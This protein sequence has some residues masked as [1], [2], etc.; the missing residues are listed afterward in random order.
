MPGLGALPLDVLDLVLLHVGSDWWGVVRL[1]CRKWHALIKR[2]CKAPRLRLRCFA[3]RRPLCEWAL[4]NDCLVPE[5]S[6]IA[7]VWTKENCGGSYKR[8]A[9]MMYAADAGA[10]D[11]LE[12]MEVH[13]R[14]IMGQC[15]QQAAYRGHL[16]VL[17]RFNRDGMSTCLAVA[18][19][20]AAGGHTH[21]ID[22]LTGQGIDTGP[23]TTSVAIR[24]GHTELAQKLIV[25]G[26]GIPVDVMYAAVCTDNLDM[27][28]WLTGRGVTLP[29]AHMY[30]AATC[31]ATKVLQHMRDTHYHM[32]METI[33]ELAV[34]HDNPKV[35][36]WV[37]SYGVEC[38]QYHYDL[39]VQMGA[40]GVQALLIRWG[41]NAP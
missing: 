38:T 28:L 18:S 29:A 20:A 21:I 12:C 27:I 6:G 22:W 11:V 4:A 26:W 19:H 5:E 3:T 9:M 1:V 10:I 37:H 17:K 25:E 2:R 32:P 36:E 8:D 34:G 14:S 13:G 30:V 7:M 33:L 23:E 15:L 39:A 40:F 35:V 31:D 41:L 16:D 24:H